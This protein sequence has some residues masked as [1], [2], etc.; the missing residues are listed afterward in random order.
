MRI[1]A[2]ALYIDFR[3]RFPSLGVYSLNKAGCPERFSAQC[4]LE[5]ANGR[6]GDRI[7]HLLVK[8]RVTFGWCQS[9]FGQ[10][11]ARIEIDR[12]VETMPSRVDIN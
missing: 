7:D 10:Q 1:N 5:V 9:I 3:Y 4:K 11:I 12:R 6:H 8:L 2:Q